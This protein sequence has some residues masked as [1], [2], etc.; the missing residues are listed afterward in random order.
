MKLQHI[1]EYLVFQTASFFVQSVPLKAVQK[2]GSALGVFVYSV[3]RFRRSVTLDNLQKAFPQMDRHSLEETAQEAFRNVGISLLELLWMPRIG[4]SEVH[5]IVK[6][7]NVELLQAA[8]AAG[9]GAL[10]LTAHFGNWELIPMAVFT[11]T[12]FP[13]TVVVKS[14][15]NRLIDKKITERRTRFGSKIVPMEFAVREVLR[16]LQ[17]GDIV[18]IAAD[19]SAAR[20]S[21]AVNFFGRMVPTFAGPAVFSLKTGAPILMGLVTRL[22]NGTYSLRF[23]EVRRD[24]LKEYSEEAVAELTRRHVAM[25]ESMIRTRPGQWLWMHRRWKHSDHLEARPSEHPD[26][27]HSI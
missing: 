11:A 21:I 24:D 27:E 4:A 14:Q 10:I 7:E 26:H 23:T 12:A 8:K 1:L 16:T 17:K 5:Q 15:S 18:I 22:E 9:K 2:I 13:L 3:L 25:A 20:E 6:L 19:Q